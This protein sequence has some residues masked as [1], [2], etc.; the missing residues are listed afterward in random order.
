VKLNASKENVKKRT[1]KSELL[2]K[3][4]E[5]SEKEVKLRTTELTKASG[6]FKKAK[7]N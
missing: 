5:A 4:S 2:K 7:A 6:L 1:A 3:K